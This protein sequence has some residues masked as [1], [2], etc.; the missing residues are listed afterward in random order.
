MGRIRMMTK[1][2]VAVM[3]GAIAT[4]AA[5]ATELFQRLSPEAR[6]LA[7]MRWEKRP[8]LIFA[9]SGED[10]DYRRQMTLLQQAAQALAER[11]I[12]VLSDLDPRTPSPLRQGFQPAGFKL[13]LVG[14]DGGVKLERDSV[15]SPD[16]L[17][18][19][20]DRMP[21]RMREAAE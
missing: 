16:E 2:G 6:D 10:P 18:A 9:S 21:M 11:D 14:K 8:V 7:G 15:L 20:I 19:V 4:Q 1:M 17:F 12:V 3:A 5:A 13:V